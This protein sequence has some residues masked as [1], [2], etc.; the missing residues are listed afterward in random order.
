MATTTRGIAYPTSGDSIAPLETHFASL[1]ST[2]DAAMDDLVTEI[3]LSPVAGLESFTGPAATGGTVDVPVTF[4]T[5][6]TTAPTVVLSVEGS[7]S[8]SPY[9]AYVY[10]TPSISGFTARV[11]R[12]AGSTAETNLFIHWMAK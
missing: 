3:G 4:L 7:A 8:M 9:V 5:P 12:L 2:A 6:F 11:Y 10:G 1:A